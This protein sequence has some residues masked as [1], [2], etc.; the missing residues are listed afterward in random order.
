MVSL[1]RS[2][3]SLSVRSPRRADGVKHDLNHASNDVEQ[4]FSLHV[5]CANDCGS[6]QFGAGVVQS[7][8]VAICVASTQWCVNAYKRRRVVCIVARNNDAVLDRMCAFL[9]PENII[10]VLVDRHRVAVGLARRSSY[11]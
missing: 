11:N 2:D 1:P 7:V 6:F 10:T 9:I 4:L 8:A 5:R 3:S